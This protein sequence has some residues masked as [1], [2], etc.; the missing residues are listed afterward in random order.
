MELRQL[1]TVRTIARVGSFA[2][3]AE[4]LGIGASTVT[5]HVQQLESELGGPLFIRQGRTLA[6]TELGESVERRAGAIAQQLEAIS[7]EAAGI[8]A[9]MRGVV[10]LGAIEPVAHRDVLPLIGAIHR[11]RP[12]VALGLDV[13]GTS[14]LSTSVA[15]GRLVCA[16]CSPPPPELELRFE[17]L[18]REPI[19]VVLPSDHELAR[20]GRPVPVGSLATQPI[21]LSEPGCAYRAETVKTV[22]ELGIDLDVRAEVGSPAALRSAVRCGFGVAL[23]PIAAHQQPGA[24]VVARPLDGVDL[25][26]DV[27]LVQGRG[28]EAFSPLLNQ[29]LSQIRRA[30]PG[31]RPDGD[32]DAPP[33]TRD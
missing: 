14:L 5:L 8:A 10:H 22:G 7:E 3:A 16:I 30:A 6:L 2:R 13:G 12:Q 27:G 32:G 28:V 33:E 1:A 31:W 19:G 26:L 4:R 17:H 18:F 23:A 25:G 9:A 15:T 21:V 24:G 11:D 20:D 29:V